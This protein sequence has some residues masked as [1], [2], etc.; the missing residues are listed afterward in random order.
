MGLQG[1]HREP[2]G[3]ADEAQYLQP[4]PAEVNLRHRETLV[5]DVPDLA[6]L[7]ACLD[8]LCERPGVS[9]PLWVNLVVLARAIDEDA[10]RWSQF[11]RLP[12]RAP[13]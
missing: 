7:R 5:H 12:V 1:H 2:G 4:N 6:A 8:H 9:V 3:A 10:Q 11:L 13:A